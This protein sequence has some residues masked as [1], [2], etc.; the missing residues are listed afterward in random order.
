VHQVS[1][2][3]RLGLA[4]ALVTSLC[5]G[6]L[7][8]ALKLALEG[9]D[10]YTI[11]WYRFA[12]ASVIL[13]GILAL[14]RRLPSLKPLGK[15]GWLLVALALFG[16]VANYIL[17]LIAL[18]YASPTVN[19]TV[20]QLSP[21]CLLLGGLIVFKERFSRRQWIGFAVLVPGLLLFFN[22]RL[23]E[24]TQLDRGLGLGVLL[25]LF[26]S[27]LWAGYALAQ[28]QLLKTLSSQQILFVLY[29]GAVLLIL[30]MSHPGEL[31]ELEPLPF[32]MLAFSCA[33]TLI[34]YGAFAEALEHWEVSRVSAV[35]ALA[36][37]FTI[38]GM[39]LVGTLAPGLLA[40]EA[41]NG[42]SIGGALMVVAGSAMTALG[43]GP[44]PG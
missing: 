39:G 5:W 27:V 33:N 16:L 9:M 26:A 20:I 18:D 7:P 13:G 4:L 35:L 6:I 10:A 38:V 17:Y 23:G 44:E 28:K 1:G 40:P 21:I 31:H 12:V 29:V 32:W 41:L 43:G 2:R 14:T 15:R 19:Q 24:L 22:N 11:T 8:I 42:L 25:L 3:W 34:A 37:L 36:P 30:P